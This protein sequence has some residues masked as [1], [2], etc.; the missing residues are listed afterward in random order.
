LARH[1]ETLEGDE[2][3]ISKFITKVTE[4]N[5]ITCHKVN[6]DRVTEENLTEKENKDNA[7]EYFARS[8]FP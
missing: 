1:A 6:V 7:I 4:P 5:S 2:E 8:H 3:I